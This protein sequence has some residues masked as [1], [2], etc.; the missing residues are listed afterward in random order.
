MRTMKQSG[1]QFTEWQ[2]LRIVEGLGKNGKWRQ[3]MAVVEWL[4]G[5]KERKEFRSR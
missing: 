5:N 3:A 1:L 4:Y 2:L